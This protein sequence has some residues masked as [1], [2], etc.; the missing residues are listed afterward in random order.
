M[1]ILTKT[2]QELTPPEDPQAPSPTLVDREFGDDSG[3]F[4]NDG[5]CD[6]TRF[7]G[8]GEYIYPW[9]SK[10]YDGKDA[11]DCRTLVDE[12]LIRWR[13]AR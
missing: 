11:T 9:V 4:A 10:E 12:D 5:Q 8:P 6:D 2:Q 1:E 7:E 13:D 3:L